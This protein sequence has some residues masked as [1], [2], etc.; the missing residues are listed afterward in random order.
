MQSAKSN[1]AVAHP[2][3]CLATDKQVHQQAWLA[4][5]QA[6]MLKED[7]EENEDGGENT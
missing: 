3:A 1:A 7:K 4:A 5:A 6:H 2:R